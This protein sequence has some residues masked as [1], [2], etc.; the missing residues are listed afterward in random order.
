MTAAGHI[1]LDLA[2]VFPAGASMPEPGKLT[3]TG[4][5]KLHTGGSVANTGLALK[6]LG[7]DVS[8]LGKIGSDPFGTLVAGIVSGYG[9]GG[10]IAD[11]AERTGYT[12]VMAPEGVDRMFLHNPGANDSF[13]ADDVPDAELE[14]SALMHF[15]YPTLMR[16]M[17]ERNGAETVKLFSRAHASG[18]MTSLDLTVPD[19]AAPAG[20]ADWQP[21]LAAVLP[22]TDFFVPSFEELCFMLDRPLYERLNAGGDV[23]GGADIV[24]DVLPLARRCLCMGCGTVL[25]KCGTKGMVWAAGTAPAGVPAPD[26]WTACEGVQPCLPAD[27]V[28]S[29]SGAGDTAIAAFLYA[30]L[31][32]YTPAECAG[33]AAAEGACCVTAWDALSG[34]KPLPELNAKYHIIS[35]SEMK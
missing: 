21:F 29:A 27:R 11:P 4:E 17:Y 34:L 15:G 24:R 1:C 28:R 25:I 13:V 8:L 32:G 5:M 23:I 10:L 18:C 31:Q 3:V 16:R 33:F 2:P 26:M 30:M 12:V 22:L 35:E 6:I 7:A 19:P 14:R 9:A 20:R